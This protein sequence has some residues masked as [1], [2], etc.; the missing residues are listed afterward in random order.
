MERN[1]GGGW[2]KWAVAGGGG[3]WR[4]GRYDDMGELGKGVVKGEG[5]GRERKVS[6][7]QQLLSDRW[8]HG[9]GN[10]RQ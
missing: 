1:G 6:R 5:K 7:F 9:S 4:L 2:C 10:R 8:R 3:S